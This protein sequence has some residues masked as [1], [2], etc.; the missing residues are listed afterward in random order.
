[1]SPKKKIKHFF[2]FL[3]IYIFIEPLAAGWPLI[4]YVAED[5]LE[6]L[7]LLPSVPKS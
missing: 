7:A 1:M 6:A 3:F 4:H 5:G 2:Y